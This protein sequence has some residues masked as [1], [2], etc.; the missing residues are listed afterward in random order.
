MAD[1]VSKENIKR[2]SSGWPQESLLV[3]S[4]AWRPPG[5]GQSELAVGSIVIITGL[6]SNSEHNDKKGQLCERASDGSWIVVIN[7]DLGGRKPLGV[8]AE[9]LR[10]PERSNTPTGYVELLLPT[11]TCCNKQWEGSLRLVNVI[12]HMCESAQH[13]RAQHTGRAAT[14]ECA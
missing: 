11:C 10:L 1:A 4:F 6:T 2:M 3:D 14:C 9:H 13:W 12:K 8:S 5:S 7:D